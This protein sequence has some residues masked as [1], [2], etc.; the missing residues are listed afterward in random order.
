MPDFSF[1]DGNSVEGGSVRINTSPPRRRNVNSP[2]APKDQSA[3]LGCLVVLAICGGCVYIVS[4]M[5]EQTAADF[6]KDDNRLLAV[7][8]AQSHIKS[9]LIAPRSAKWPG[10]LDG[11]DTSTHATKL[12]DGTYM[13]RSFV[14]SQNRMGALLRTHYVVHLRLMKDGRAVILSSELLDDD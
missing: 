14:D 1:L 5:P 6:E 7:T 8:N 4:R 2:A 9:R 3:A 10:I 12:N 11:I 13:V